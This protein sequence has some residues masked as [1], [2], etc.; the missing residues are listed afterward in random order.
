MEER[1]FMPQQDVDTNIKEPP[2]IDA[3]S[4]SGKTIENQLR[5]ILNKWNIRD[6]PRS[7]QDTFADNWDRKQIPLDRPLKKIKSKQNE[8]TIPW[9]KEFFKKVPRLPL[10]DTSLRKSIDYVVS[11]NSK[12]SKSTLLIIKISQEL[13]KDKSM[14]RE[15]SLKT[16]RDIR[17]HSQE[18]HRS[19]HMFNKLDQKYL[20]N[21]KQIVLLNEREEAEQKTVDALDEECR[22]LMERL[23]KEL[24]CTLEL[25]MKRNSHSF[26]HFA[27]I[28]AITLSLAYLGYH[29][30]TSS[31]FEIIKDML[32]SQTKK[33]EGSSLYDWAAWACRP[34]KSL[35]FW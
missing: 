33:K 7:V 6:I 18:I 28:M 25:N 14:Q 17:E 19:M 31:Q 26:R 23:K 4:P 12:H 34:M 16:I 11:C 20:A 8:I 21:M 13:L 2:L 30:R 15:M 24:N 5:A 10:I 9:Q 22:V 29:E 3:P 35:K 27:L 32:E 1:K